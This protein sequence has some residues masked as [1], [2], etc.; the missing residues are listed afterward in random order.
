MPLPTMEQNF[1][2][3]AALQNLTRTRKDI[4]QRWVFE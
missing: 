1:H 4:L 3:A 2:T